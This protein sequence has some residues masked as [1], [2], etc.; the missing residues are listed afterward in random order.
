MSKPRYT[1]PEIYFGCKRVEGLPDSK[2][3]KNIKKEWFIYWNHFREKT[4]RL[5]RARIKDGINKFHTVSERYEEAKISIKTQ[6][7]LLKEGY[8]PWPKDLP[9]AIMPGANN[10]MIGFSEALDFA[11][12]I[13]EP[14]LRKPSRPDY[15]STLNIFKE[16]IAK[17]NLS[18]FP[19]NTIVRKQIRYILAEIHSDRKFGNRRYNNF[20]I[21]IS[22][23]FSVLVD[24]DIINFNPC[25]EIKRKEVDEDTD[26]FESL[27]KKERTAVRNRLE[28]NKPGF[29]LYVNLIRHIGT[30]RTETILLQARDIIIQNDYICIS[31]EKSKVDKK[32]WLPI[33]DEFRDILIA[34]LAKCNSPKDYLFS[35]NFDP[36]EKHLHP[37]TATDWWERL[38]QNDIKEGGLGIKKKMYALKHTAAEL[39]IDSGAESENVATLFGHSDTT[40]LKKHYAPDAIERKAARSIIEHA[41]SF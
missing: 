41:E 26:Y 10:N 38:V 27:T 5:E 30:R 14:E 39:Y 29:W 12:K 23:L 2:Q 8:Y 32:R 24:E 35:N 17:L 16:K 20:L 19:V 21:N 36:G 13:K 15:K 1:T 31:K 7:E 4:G 18:Y 9:V 25:H 40:M 22:S 33:L 6:I 3:P 28:F 34:Q 11:W 37:D